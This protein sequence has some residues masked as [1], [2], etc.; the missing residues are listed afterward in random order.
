MVGCLRDDDDAHDDP[1]IRADLAIS[2]RA[3]WAANIV[4][5]THHLSMSKTMTMMIIDAVVGDG[6]G[7]AD[8]DDD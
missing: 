3:S 1:V 8:D 2:L 4:E 5:K 7:G 6:D